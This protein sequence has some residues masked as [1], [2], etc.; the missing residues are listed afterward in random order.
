MYMK[1]YFRGSGN[2]APFVI[3]TN[4]DWAIS[5]WTARKKHNPKIFWVFA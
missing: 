2:K 1:I 3:E 5:Y 4:L